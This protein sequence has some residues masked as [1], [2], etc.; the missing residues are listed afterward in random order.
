MSNSIRTCLWFRDGRGQAAQK[1]IQI[2]LEP[3]LS[4]W[5][6]KND[7]LRLPA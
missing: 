7:K 3:E 4:I 5:L 1:L 6:S 2:K